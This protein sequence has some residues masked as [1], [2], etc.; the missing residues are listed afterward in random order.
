MKKIFL[1]LIVLSTNLFA[2]DRQYDQYQYKQCIHW[3]VRVDD[4]NRGNCLWGEERDY[5]EECMRSSQRAYQECMKDCDL[6]VQNGGKR[7]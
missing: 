1:F 4:A 3:C 7:Q 6:E 2:S 5:R